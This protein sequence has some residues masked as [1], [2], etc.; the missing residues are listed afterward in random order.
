MLS[1]SINVFLVFLCSIMLE[2]Y[3]KHA[4]LSPSRCQLLSQG[5]QFLL[6]NKQL[7]IVSFSQ[8]LQGKNPLKTTLHAT[9]NCQNKQSTV[10]IFWTGNSKKKKKPPN[11]PSIDREDRH[12]LTS[13]SLFLS[14]VGGL[15]WRLAISSIFLL[16]WAFSCLSL[17]S[18]AS[19]FDAAF[20]DLKP[21]LVTR[22]SLAPLEVMASSLVS[23]TTLWRKGHFIRAI[24]QQCGWR[25]RTTDSL[26][27]HEAL[28]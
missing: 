27:H 12:L 24:C 14:E 1:S 17:S 20:P 15:T 25:R 9:Q 8:R 23:P 2:L 18:S 22:F 5:F 13:S 26:T 16:R 28:I 4:Y 10:F 7:L 11:N 3:V 19:V 21:N 6:L